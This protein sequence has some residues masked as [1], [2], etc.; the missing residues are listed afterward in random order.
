MRLEMNGWVFDV[1]ISETRMYSAKVLADHC[2]CG[3]CRNF[4][5]AV[6]DAYPDLR[7]F[8]AQFGMH[9]ETP[10]E[11]MPFEPTVCTVSYCIS[12][13]ILRSNPF[14]L[15]GG[16]TVF[17]V[18]TQEEMPFETQCKSPYFVLTSGFLELPWVLEDDMNEVISTANEPDF[19][20]KMWNKLLNSTEE[21]SIISQ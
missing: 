18:E 10:E 21:T 11:L 20:K 17:S 13:R 15:E 5:Q 16:G 12:G 3:Y 7:P 9:V 1:D 8:L 2:Q 14:P 6:D 19:L 4:Y